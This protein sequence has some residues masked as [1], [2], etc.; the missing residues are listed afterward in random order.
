M[1]QKEMG[2]QMKK[3]GKKKIQCWESNQERITK[4]HFKKDYSIAQK[5]H[6]L[7]F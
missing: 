2:K 1:K 4:E 7:F 5:N 6:S 3:S